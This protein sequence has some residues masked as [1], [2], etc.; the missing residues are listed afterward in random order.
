MAGVYGTPIV[1]CASDLVIALCI[2]AQAVNDEVLS[3]LPAHTAVLL[4][5]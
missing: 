4:H 2:K 3:S 5:C 1:V